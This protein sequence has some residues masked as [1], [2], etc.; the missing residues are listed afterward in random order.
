M[1]EVGQMKLTDFGMEVQSQCDREGHDF[2]YGGNAGLPPSMWF[3]HCKR[4]YK[5]LLTKDKEEAISILGELN[6]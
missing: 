1:L 5:C 4:C 6:E 3:F 2:R